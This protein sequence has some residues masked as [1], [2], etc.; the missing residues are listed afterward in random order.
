MPPEAGWR[1]CRWGVKPAP[2]MAVTLSGETA[3]TRSRETAGTRSRETAYMS[4]PPP[5]PSVPLMHV[6][7]PEADVHQE[8][9][10]QQVPQQVFLQGH[11]Q[12]KLCCLQAPFCS[13][14]HTQG[15]PSG[16]VLR[17]C[18]CASVP[19]CHAVLVC[20]CVCAS[21]GNA[22]SLLLL[23][24]VCVCQA[25]MSMQE[26]ASLRQWEAGNASRMEQANPSQVP[27]AHVRFFRCGRQY[28]W[29]TTCCQ[30]TFEASARI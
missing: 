28:M 7:P 19:I 20:V 13:W 17:V 18:A 6:A 29:P 22:A 4:L 10:P 8:Q 11:S 16:H 2:Q 9:V 23:C 3:V 21:E 1:V 5:G 25:L 26:E 24:E 30:C 14:L 27:Q 15:Q 12:A